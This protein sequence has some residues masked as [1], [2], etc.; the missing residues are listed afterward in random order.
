MTCVNVAGLKGV[1][2]DPQLMGIRVVPDTDLTL[3]PVTTGK[4]H[5]VLTWQGKLYYLDDDTVNPL[6]WRLA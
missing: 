5:E 4:H 6:L 2:T 1:L 3:P